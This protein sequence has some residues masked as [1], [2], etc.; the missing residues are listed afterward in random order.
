MSIEELKKLCIKAAS[1]PI[2][3]RSIDDID[4]LVNFTADIP[5][6]NKEITPGNE[7]HR[8]ICAS[9]DYLHLNP[10]ITLYNQGDEGYYYNI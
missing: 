7:E 5:L 9:L 1:L 3:N 2:N 10:N 8:L 6:F 4:V